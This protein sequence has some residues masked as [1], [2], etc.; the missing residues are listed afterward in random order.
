MMRCGLCHEFVM[1]CESPFCHKFFGVGKKVYCTEDER[2][3][4]S[5]ECFAVAT[6][7]FEAPLITEQEGRSPGADNTETVVLFRCETC[8]I[9][10]RTLRD[11]HDALLM[12]TQEQF[13]HHVNENYNGFALWVYHNF[14]DRHAQVLVT[15]MLKVRS[16]AL[17]AY[18]VGECVRTMRRDRT[19]AALVV[20]KSRRV[21]GTEDD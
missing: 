20:P 2:H 8:R 6:Q 16:R 21:Y 19:P 7:T 18:K 13:S 3:F 14:P 15:E 12:M 4:C 9:T 11:L 10:I 17:M 5:L 1:R